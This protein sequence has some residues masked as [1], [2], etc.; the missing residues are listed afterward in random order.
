MSKNFMIIFF[1]ILVIL[2]AI[3]LYTNKALNLV[4]EKSTILTVLKILNWGVLP[5]ALLG[6]IISTSIVPASKGSQS[7]YLMYIFTGVLIIFYGPKIF[8]VIIHL[9]EDL[10]NAGLWLFE[11]IQLNII[12]TKHIGS[13]SRFIWLTR[14]ALVLYII[15]FL[16]FLKG[17]LYDRFNYKIT[18]ETIVSDKISEAF[19]E[20]KIIH[21]SD[22]HIGAFYNNEDKLKKAVK[23]VNALEPDLILF[24]GDLVVNLAN[25]LN[26]FKVLEQLKAK[27]GIYSILGNHDYGEYYNW[28]SEEDELQNLQDLKT[29][30]KQL[31]FNLLLNKNKII[32]V[33]GDSIAIIGVENWGKPPFPQYGDLNNALKGTENIAFKILLS[34]DPTH[35]DV[36]VKEKT[37]VDLTLSGH[38][39]GMQ[40]GII[41]KNIK[42]SPIHLKYDKWGGLYSENGQHLYVN[43]G[44]GSIGYPGRVGIRPEIT[45]ITLKS[46]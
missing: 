26:D 37:D 12:K 23:Q 4:F 35:W 2:L 43:V 42:W 33:N 29:Y 17:I 34:H 16:L 19:N 24:T 46:K 45:L 30:Q 13:Y 11:K 22:I 41:T 32:S 36:E 20:F 15:F 3:D 10:L 28:K 38:T 6:I 21:L 44:L 1:I 25:E 40:F 5:F 27:H 39:H 7:I 8:F 18:N 31:G 9:I 14:G